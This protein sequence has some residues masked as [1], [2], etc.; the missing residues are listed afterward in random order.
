[1]VAKR[2]QASYNEGMNREQA[3]ARIVKVAPA[4]RALGAAALYLFGSTARN[5]AKETSDVDIFIDRDPTKAMGF[6]E[7]FDMEEILQ[8]ALGTKVDLGTRT[9]LHPML[10][11]D[12]EQT[13]IRVF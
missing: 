4:I 6:I 3:I 8:E 11:A 5:E 10:R 13:A 1:M 9:G 12:I 2:A 7:F